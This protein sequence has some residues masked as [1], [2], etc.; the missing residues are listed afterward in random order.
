MSNKSKFLPITRTEFGFVQ[1]A[2]YQQHELLDEEIIEIDSPF[3]T[4]FASGSE[5]F[6]FLLIGDQNAGLIEVIN[7]II[8]TTFRQI[9]FPSQLYVSTRPKFS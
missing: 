5:V 2:A 8:F 4:K 3:A 9:Y 7:E 1:K 6:T